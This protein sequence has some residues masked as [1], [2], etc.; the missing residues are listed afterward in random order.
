MDGTL[1]KS[2]IKGLYNNF[3]NHDYLHQGYCE[4]VKTASKMGYRIVWITMRSLSLY[5]FTKNYIQSCIAVEGVL[6]TLPEQLL[7]AVTK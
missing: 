5:S 4:L 7:S 3:Y 6:L 2:D 1:T